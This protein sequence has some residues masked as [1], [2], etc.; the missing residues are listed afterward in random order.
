M[1]SALRETIKIYISDNLV[2][3]LTQVILGAILFAVGR[4]LIK[5]LVVKVKN[6]IE[7][8]DLTVDK[9]TKKVAG[10]IWSIVYTTLMI[11]NVLL[12]FALRG[13]DVGIILGALSIGIWFGLE[14]TIKNMV[15]GIL[16][17]TNKKIKL[18]DFIEILGSLQI[19]GTIEEINIRFTVVRTLDQ[20][21]VIVPNGELMSS[22]IKTLKTEPLI[23]GE[24]IIKVPRHINTQ[25]V[26]TLLVAVINKHDHV[27][28]KEQT[29]SLITEFD[30]HGIVFTNYFYLNPQMWKSAYIINSEIRTTLSQV[31]QKYWIKAPYENI[32]INVE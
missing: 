31:F 3:L 24:L 7:D 4:I 27:I 15:S 10:T 9:Y 16:M 14:D 19:L 32:V 1:L 8:Q 26:K 6:K 21:R 29:S 20:R 17:I 11:F 18:W 25:Q 12:V 28:N 22:P 30:S 23:R 2:N 13:F 5:R